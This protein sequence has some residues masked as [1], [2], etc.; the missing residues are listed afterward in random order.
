M[1]ITNPKVIQSAEK[2]FLNAV[3]DHLDWDA[4]RKVVNKKM[5]QCSLEPRGGELVVHDNG[6]G[7]RVDVH[8]AMDVGIMFDRHGNLV[9]DDVPFSGLPETS[10]EGPV[11][12]AVKSADAGVPPVSEDRTDSPLQAKEAAENIAV[13]E[14]ADVLELNDLLEDTDPY[15]SSKDAPASDDDTDGD[16]DLESLFFKE[17][18][19]DDDETDVFWK[20]K[21]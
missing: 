17:K 18:D 11:E 10:E 13:E 21:S 15:F 3:K 14:D 12:T 20:D 2:A 1:K 8:C 4:I 9:S 19:G 6:V 16:E 5:A 7:F